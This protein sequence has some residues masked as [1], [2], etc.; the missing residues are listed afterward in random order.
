MTEFDPER[1]TPA[2]RAAWQAGYDAAAAQGAWLC[3]LLG[4]GARDD[5]VEAAYDACAR[6]LILM[7]PEERR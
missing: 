4:R 6:A 7:R 5:A 2:E 3:L 1:A